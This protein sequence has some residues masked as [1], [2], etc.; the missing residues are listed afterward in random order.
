MSARISIYP[1]IKILFVVL[2]LVGCASA[3]VTE[4]SSVSAGEYIAKPG[5]IIV[6]D[7]SATPSDIP[8]TSA[9]AGHYAR[10]NVPQTPAQIEAGRKLGAIV[11]AALVGEIIRMGMPAERAGGAPPNIDNIVI[12]GEFVVIDEGSRAKR[13]TIGFGEGA[14]KLKTLVEAYQVTPSGL[15][16]LGSARIKARGG[17]MPGVI[18][19]VIVGA[20]TGSVGTSLIVAG[21][22]N[23]IQELG[24][25]RM[26][27]LGKS[28]AKEIAKVLRDAFR[29]RGWI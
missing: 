15:R 21:A 12:S 7:I 27:S 20:A 3:K 9:I 1:P 6:Y 28:T 11:S 10:R 29:K 2:F 5:R 22:M 16:P 8:P 14:G 25:E 26:T 13:M 17:R 18:L 23:V 4:R 24:P 19:P